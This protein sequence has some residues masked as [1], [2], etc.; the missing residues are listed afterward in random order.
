MSKI[1]VV[2]FPGN[3]CENETARAVQAAGMESKVLRWNQTKELDSYDGYIIPGG[4]S[5]EDRIRAGVIAA[6]DPVISMIKKEALKGKVV[7]GICNGCQ[8]LA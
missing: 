2:M 3:N 1:A 7:L 4:W 6:K 8:I 5:Y